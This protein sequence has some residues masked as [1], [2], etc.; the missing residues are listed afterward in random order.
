[1]KTYL[2]LTALALLALC[3]VP[4]K[5][6]NVD[7]LPTL[8][9]AEVD[10]ANDKISVRDASVSASAG[11]LRK[12]TI[13][14][15]WKALGGTNVSPTELS[16]LDGASG[17]LQPAG[18]YFYDIANYTTANQ[19]NG[20]ADATA[21]VQALMNTIETAMKANN[22]GNYIVWMDEEVEL[23]ID[24]ALQTTN[25]NNAQIT[26]P[27]LD[28]FSDAQCSL[29]FRGPAPVSAGFST[30]SAIP[31]PT[32]G[33]R[34]RSTLATG[35]GTRPC[36][37]GGKG[38]TG[39]AWPFTLINVWF[40]NVVVET[41]PNPLISGINC[42]YVAGMEVNNTAVIAGTYSVA[43]V[44]EP[45]T[46][47][48]Y[49][50]IGPTIN[51]GVYSN[52]HNAFVLGFR[53][54]YLLN[55]H[56]TGYINAFGCM[57]ALE[58]GAGYHGSFLSR[59][60]AVDCKTA[61][62]GPASVGS[63]QSARL[64]V[65]LLM[66]E[67]LSSGIFSGG[68]DIEDSG[69]YLKGRCEYAVVLGNVGENDSFLKNGGTNFECSA[70]GDNLRPVWNAL[71]GT[72]P[73]I[74]FLGT[75][76]SRTIQLTGNTTFTG[77]GYA[78]GRK[79]ILIVT[80]D[81]S[82]R[83][84]SWPGWTWMGTAPTSLDS[85]KVLTVELLCSGSAAANVIARYSEG[86]NAVGFTIADTFTRANSA[87]VVGA[88]STGNITPTQRHGTWG[89]SGNELYISTASS[90]STNV[91]TVV[92]DNGSANATVQADFKTPASGAFAQY[93]ILRSTDVNNFIYVEINSTGALALGKRIGGTYTTL[94]GGLSGQGYTNSQTY[95]VKA[96]MSGTSIEV[97]VGGV[98]KITYNTSTG[99]E[100]V[101]AHG[102]GYFAGSVSP[103][104][105]TFDNLSITTP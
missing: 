97:F 67:H 55:E 60:G 42:F 41:V 34:I 47:T 30:V 49:G 75:P 13:A 50:I 44:V 38:P 7:N 90:A 93:L 103:A 66:V 2:K 105:G 77:S 33:P 83:T 57:T 46:S 80:G 28:A 98:S 61:I 6:Q 4:A 101:T 102:V 64:S 11:A 94:P 43:D 29:I 26:L 76:Q 72:S 12:M 17:P 15:F 24:G 32:K 19:R 39:S 25:G 36:V 45:T 99:L 22:G 37:I 59:V 40:E 78:Q 70:Q 8:T 58:M 18:A 96:V 81:S 88:S 23:R 54:G 71:S 9:G 48:S 14:E 52:F 35:G 65:G 82:T 95:T 89:I 74:T 84:L 20:T 104:L 86:N 62:R 87:S 21:A 69:N 53:T 91:N 100:N 92:W 16:Y 51:N 79:Y 5:G 63:Y 73:A 85:G 31:E 27:A 68:N 10:L 1:M 3:T 56:S